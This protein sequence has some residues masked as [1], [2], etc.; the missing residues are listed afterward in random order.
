MEDLPLYECDGCGA[1]CKSFPI[2][3]SADDARREP[4]IK[5][6][7]RALAPWQATPEGSFRLFPIASFTACVFLDGGDRCSIYPT[8]P[9]I[10]RAF[11]A[12]APQCQEARALHGLPPLAPKA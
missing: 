7:A 4:R 8:R 1:C 12:G 2:F 6:E 10:C 9:D 3:A 5:A 11:P